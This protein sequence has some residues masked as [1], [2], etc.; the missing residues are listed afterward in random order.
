MTLA[1]I[2][3]FIIVIIHTSQLFFIGDCDYP[4]FFAWL[5]LFNVVTYLILFIHFYY[6]VSCCERIILLRFGWLCDSVCLPKW[7]LLDI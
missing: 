2:V 4:I 1:Q 6:L 5:N 7:Y 3:Q